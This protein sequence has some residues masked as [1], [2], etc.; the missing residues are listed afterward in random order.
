[1]G[2]GHDERL[3]GGLRDVEGLNGLQILGDGADEGQAG[4]GSEAGPA[5]ERVA[6]GRARVEGG[7]ASARTGSAFMGEIVA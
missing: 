2:A 7:A 5:G 3:P 1:M 4:K 6:I